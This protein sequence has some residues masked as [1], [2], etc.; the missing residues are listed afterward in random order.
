MRRRRGV[1]ASKAGHLIF[2]ERLRVARVFLVYTQT[3]IASKFD[4]SFDLFMQVMGL[5]F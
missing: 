3:E 5:S 2:G 4:V 1:S